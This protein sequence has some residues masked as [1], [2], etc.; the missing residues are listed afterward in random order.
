M[1]PSGVLRRTMGWVLRR[2]PYPCR[3]PLLKGM[4]SHEWRWFVQPDPL[5]KEMEFLLRMQLRG[6]VV[7]DVGANVGVMTLYF[8]KA[9]G[10]HGKVV[11]FEPNPECFRR[12]L[13][14][15]RLN[16]LYWVTPLQKAI[17]SQPGTLPLILPGL[18]LVSTFVPKHAERWLKEDSTIP[19]NQVQVEVD[20]LDRLVGTSQIPVPD[21]IK[22]DVEG[23]E[24]EVLQGSQQTIA[25]HHPVLFIEI[26]GHT[27]GA[28]LNEAVMKFLGT[29][30]YQVYHV[31]TG[32]HAQL[33]RYEF[34]NG[35]V[36]CVHESSR[37]NPV[38]ELKWK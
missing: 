14:N 33:D 31:E 17:G 34:V 9:V 35:H 25:D 24:L 3:H 30:G 26:H 11:S 37:I 16:R 5:D 13:R 20:T 4:W 12:L 6:A 19:P 7:F 28:L 18:H 2:F 22:I 8:A 10:R 38:P 21:F 36:Y 1:S 32:S 29:N 15:V 27:V 23:Y